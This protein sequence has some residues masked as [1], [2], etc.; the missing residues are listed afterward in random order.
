MTVASVI[1]L[2]LVAVV[3]VAL[4]LRRTELQGAAAIL[5]L[6][7]LLFVVVAAAVL[8]RPVWQ[9]SGT[10]AI[11]SLGLPVVV[12]LV[13][14]LTAGARFGAAVTAVAA[15]LLLVWSLLLALAF[16]L[17]L[18]PAALAETAAAVAQ[19]RPAT[20]DRGRG[21]GVSRGA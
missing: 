14:L 4:T 19:L 6:L 16:G 3:S 13:P 15:V 1:V 5:R 10:F 7:A 18:L 12:T 2:L 11:W 9:D 8:M 17:F 20:P 21:V